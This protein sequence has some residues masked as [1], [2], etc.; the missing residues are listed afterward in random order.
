MSQKQ[1]RTL[2]FVEEEDGTVT[3]EVEYIDGTRG[4]FRGVEVKSMGDA[5]PDARAIPMT[6][7]A[8]RIVR[9]QVCR[10]ERKLDAKGLVVE[11]QFRGGRCRGSGADPVRP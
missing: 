4:R 2:G 5:E 11:H 8:T 9:C 1:V 6:F 7:I 3:M 10:A